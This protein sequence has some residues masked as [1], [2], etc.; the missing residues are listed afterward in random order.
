MILGDY[1][2]IV[3]RSSPRL[4]SAVRE[5]DNND[6]ITQTVYHDAHVSNVNNDDKR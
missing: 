4:R 3:D 6:N 1:H 2:V 5:D